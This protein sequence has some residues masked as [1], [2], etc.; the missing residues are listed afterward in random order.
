MIDVNAYLNVTPS[1]GSDADNNTKTKAVSG[2][3]DKSSHKTFAETI[4]DEIETASKKQKGKKYVYELCGNVIKVL[5]VVDGQVKKCIKQIP[6][7]NA[8]IADLAKVTNASPTE[9]TEL[10]Q[11]ENAKLNTSD[12]KS[13]N[14]A[15]N[16][17][18]SKD[19]DT[20]SQ[21]KVRAVVQGSL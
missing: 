7:K 11:A 14:P 4:S 5:E 15:S 12:N 18:Q 16:G 1:K 13:Q 9:L 20:N 19:S 6:V 17:N 3:N 10:Q 2:D 21:V 8:S